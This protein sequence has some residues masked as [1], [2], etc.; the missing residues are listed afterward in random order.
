MFLTAEAES[1]LV[2]IPGIDAARR[3]VPDEVLDQVTVAGTPDEVVAKLR[4]LYDAGTDAIGLWL[5]PTGDAERVAALT[6]R[7]VLPHLRR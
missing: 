7:E 5:F 1:A 4:R 2:R 3:P 6:A